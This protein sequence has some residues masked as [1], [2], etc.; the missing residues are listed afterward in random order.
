MYFSCQGYLLFIADRWLLR[1][2]FRAL[3]H[4]IIFTS[5]T[6]SRMSCCNFKVANTYA[7]IPLE[8]SCIYALSMTLHKSKGA[9]WTSLLSL[10]I[11]SDQCTHHIHFWHSVSVRE[12]MY[13]RMARWWAL[14]TCYLRTWHSRIAEGT[15]VERGLSNTDPTYSNFLSLRR[16]KRHPAVNTYVRTHDATRWSFTM[17]HLLRSHVYMCLPETH[18]IISSYLLIYQHSTL[19]LSTVQGRTLQYV[20]QYLMRLTTYDRLSCQ[21][22]IE[23]KIKVLLETQLLS[24]WAHWW[25]VKLPLADHAYIL[26]FRATSSLHPWTKLGSGAGTETTDLLTVKV[27]L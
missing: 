18:Q 14:K 4:T 19:A 26:L 21:D 2:V 24:L 12:S 13:A 25:P 20:R 8:H 16:L 9:L 27:R 10:H 11:N 3:R 23:V 22:W 1:W 17:Q 5:G 15:A 6:F 7:Q